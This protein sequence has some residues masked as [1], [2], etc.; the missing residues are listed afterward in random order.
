MICKKVSQYL[1]FAKILEVNN[2]FNIGQQNE[3]PPKLGFHSPNQESKKI[4]MSK[5]KKFC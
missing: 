1:I 2:C 3:S 4:P 5:L